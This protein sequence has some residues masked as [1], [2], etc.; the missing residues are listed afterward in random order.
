MRRWRSSRFDEVDTDPL[1]SVANLVDLML[2]FACGLLVALAARTDLLAR[3]AAE[4]Q[5]LAV[6]RGRELPRLPESVEGSAGQ[7]LESVG[8]VYRDP[9]TGK[10]ILIGK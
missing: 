6:E 7:G 5:P 2:V 9:K 3:L 1:G 10:L 8:Q 4:R